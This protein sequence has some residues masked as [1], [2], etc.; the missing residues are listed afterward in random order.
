[1]H[2]SQF[3]LVFDE[4]ILA[5]LKRLGGNVQL[6]LLFRKMFDKMEEHGP[7]AD[8]LIDSRLFLYEIKCKRPP[9][10]LYYMHVKETNE[11]YVFEYE[12]KTSKE[13]QK[14]TINRIRRGIQNPKSE[15]VNFFFWIL[16]MNWRM[17][18]Y[19]SVLRSVSSS[20]SI[21]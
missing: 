20:V 10:R 16:L 12:M 6:R 11:L 17:R 1:M 8:G 2:S 14:G 5:Q 21:L 9:L 4:V 13:K 15:R 7:R 18:W 19:K 3:K